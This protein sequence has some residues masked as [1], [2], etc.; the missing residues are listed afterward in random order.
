MYGREKRAKAHSGV[1]TRPTE[2]LDIFAL[3][4]YYQLHLLMQGFYIWVLLCV[5]PT[6][7]NISL[8]G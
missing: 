6:V 3:K 2:I 4:Y 5:Q 8:E 1:V 7:S